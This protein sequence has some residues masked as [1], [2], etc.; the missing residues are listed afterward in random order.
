MEE[1]LERVDILTEKRLRLGLNDLPMK[2]ALA[3]EGWDPKSSLE[4]VIDYFMMDFENAISPA[5]TSS[6]IY[7][8]T[9]Q[10][11]DVIVT[12]SRG[13]AHIVEKMADKISDRILSNTVVASVSYSGK[14]IL[15]VL[16]TVCEI[17]F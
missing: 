3:M 4:N 13:F 9:G 14:H 15:P 8:A 2:T 5:V 17:H 11:Q 16:G 7:G 6:R 1:A 12:D 10:R